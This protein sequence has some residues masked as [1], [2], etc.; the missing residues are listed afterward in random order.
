MPAFLYEARHESGKV[1]VV[2]DM[3]EYVEK[4]DEVE[5]SRE[6]GMRTNE[7]RKCGKR[8]IRESEHFPCRFRCI[9]VEV[10][11]PDLP[12]VFICP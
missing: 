11:S 12:P 4:C 5:C 7:F 3:F 8:N 2:V 9:G 1:V 6:L 10:Y